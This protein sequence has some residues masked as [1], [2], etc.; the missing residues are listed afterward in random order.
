MRCLIY[1]KSTDS[2]WVKDYF[3]DVE[4][5][6]LKIVNKPLLEYS[7]DLVS[8]LGVTDLRIVSD[9]S[10]KAIENYFLDGVRWGINISYSLAR[11]ED[12]LENV[13]LK[14][15]SFCKDVDMLLWDGFYFVQYDRNT[16]KE[17][18][19]FSQAF[20]CNAPSHRMIYLPSGEKLRKQTVFDDNHSSCLMIREINSVVDYYNLSMEI[21]TLRN[22]AYVLPGYSNEKDTFIGLNLVYPNSCDLNSPIMIG[23]NCRFQRDTIIG[24]N[25]IIGSNIIVDENTSVKDSIIYDNTYLGSDLDLHKKIVYKSHLISAT[26][27]EQINITDR[28][29]VSQVDL[30]VVTSYFN[31]QV[32]RIIGFIL[33]GVMFIP[34]LV[35]YVPFKLF[36]SD[37]KSDRLLSKNMNVR[38]YEEPSLLK[39]SWW[40]RL[41]LRL[42]LD[43]FT[44]LC[45]SV[46]TRKLYLVGN[47]LFTN[48]VA[49]RKL[50][51]ELP[52]YNPGV[53]S[54]IESV[55][56]EGPDVEQFYELEF[57]DN[58][59]T[60]YILGILC[61]SILRRLI[62]G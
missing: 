52:V 57:I 58:V 39:N 15:Y 12:S 5:Y 55:G 17:S 27:G 24:P 59:S 8:L 43:K 25:S 11:P 54:L 18:M 37:R 23:N 13:Y 30:G 9:G 40:G 47:H 22:K 20:C 10:I 21:L 51:S 6:L 42:T 14:N 2:L 16:V 35:L 61:S 1:A 44:Q 45:S 46:F 48:T 33:L 31:R 26:S 49:H 28:V 29:L 62:H 41:M 19:D 56:A 36:G 38:S 4:P 32:Q 3:P 50:I 34:W 7:L 53:F 60:R